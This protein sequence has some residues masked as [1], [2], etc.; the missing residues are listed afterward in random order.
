MTKLAV[1]HQIDTSMGFVLAIIG[2]LVLAFFF[3]DLDY[4]YRKG[5][6]SKNLEGR[7]QVKKRFSNPTTAYISDATNNPNEQKG[8]DFENFVLDR[9]KKEFFT[10]LEWQSDKSHN[11][12]YA[13]SNM[14]PDM[15]FRFQ[16]ATHCMHFAVECKWRKNSLNGFIEWARDYQLNNYKNFTAQHRMP[17]F[18]ILGTGGTPCSPESLFIMPINEMYS[19]VL[20]EQVLKKYYRQRKGDFF[21]D[22]ETKRLK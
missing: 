14:N 21:L 3:R 2:I 22:T 13:L 20:S 9:F 7:A 6:Y 1:I 17:V 18:V 11:G 8:K 15:V 5:Y 19:N 4:W 12:R 16:S 10:L